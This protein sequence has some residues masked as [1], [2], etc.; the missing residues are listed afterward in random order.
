MSTK[1]EWCD[2]T[3]NPVVGCTH[4]SAGCENC[5]AEVQ[6]KRL[7][8]FG[9]SQYRDVVDANGWTGEVGFH[10]PALELPFK[11]KKPRR[12]FVGSMGDLFHPKVP[13]ERRHQVFAM[14]AGRYTRQHTFMVLTKRAQEMCHWVT[15]CVTKVLPNI[16]LGVTVENQQAVDERIPWLLKTPAAVRFISYEPGLE[17]VDWGQVPFIYSADE[18]TNSYQIHWVICGC[19]S[20]PNARPFDEQWARDAKNACVAAGVPFFYKQG[21]VNGKLVKMPELDGRV[22]DEMPMTRTGG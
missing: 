16:Q 2:E 19:E 13:D 14:M 6:A 5:Y 3:I 18:G 8:G 15:R 21:R 9:Q 10:R 17:A 1:I 4:V 20:G 7:K 12:I 11:W 22:W